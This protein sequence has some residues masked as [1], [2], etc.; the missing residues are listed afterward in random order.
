MDALRRLRDFI[1]RRFR[2]VID[3]DNANGTDAPLVRTGKIT[4]FASSAAFRMSAG[5]N[6]VYKCPM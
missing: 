3:N 1:S 6:R 4:R 5:Y 2:L